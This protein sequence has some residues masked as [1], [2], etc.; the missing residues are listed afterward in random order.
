MEEALTLDFLAAGVEEDLAEEDLVEEDLAEEDLAEEDLT[1]LTDLGAGLALLLE[2]AG[3]FLA[4][5]A[6]G[7]FLWDTGGVFLGLLALGT[8]N[9]ITVLL[10]IAMGPATT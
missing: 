7:F 6:A 10:F 3:V 4:E 5:L 8:C 1:E 9:D 2:E